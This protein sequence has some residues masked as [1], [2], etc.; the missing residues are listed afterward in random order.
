MLHDDAH[1]AGFLDQNSAR[2]RGVLDECWAWFCVSAWV[3][4]WAQKEKLDDGFRSC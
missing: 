3:S 2:I 1:I 4:C